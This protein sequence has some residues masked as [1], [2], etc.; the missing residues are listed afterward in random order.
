[1]CCDEQLIEYVAICHYLATCQCICISCDNYAVHLQTLQPWCTVCSRWT[2]SYGDMGILRTILA[3]GI[4]NIEFRSGCFAISF[5]RSLSSS[6][7]STT[8]NEHVVKL[9]WFVGWARNVPF[10]ICE[11]SNR[12]IN[13]Q[14]ILNAYR[15]KCFIMNALCARMH[16]WKWHTK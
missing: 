13:A 16:M 5:L 2:N 11:A 6:L 1:M 15:E 3:C 9:W 14:P 8:H 10:S 4:L 12:P 7:C